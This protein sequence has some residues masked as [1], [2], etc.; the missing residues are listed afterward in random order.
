MANKCCTKDQIIKF[1]AN[2][3]TQPNYAAAVELLS[4]KNLLFGEPAVV[5]YKATDGTVK[6]LMAVGA[7]NTGTEILFL[8]ETPES[9][10]QVMEI[11]NNLQHI[12]GDG[13]IDVSV[14]GK[15]NLI[16]AVNWLNSQISSTSG[17]TDYDKLINKPSINDIELTGNKSLD[18]LGIQPKGDY[19]EDSSYVH[20]DNNFTNELKDKLDTLPN[21]KSIGTGLNL[22]PDGVLVNTGGGGSGSSINDSS[23]SYTTTWSSAKI[24][25]EVINKVNQEINNSTINGGDIDGSS[26]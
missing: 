2:T 12:V 20:T 19:I 26:W 7:D 8:H 1:L 18:D 11:V 23:I 22:T 13:T 17:T 21:I 24:N 5:K 25:S 6:M 3:E 10:D 15:T 16:D 9:I 14:G 4:R